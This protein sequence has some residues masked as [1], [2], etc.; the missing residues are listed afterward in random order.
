M[1]PPSSSKLELVGVRQWNKFTLYLY[2]L[3]SYSRSLRY[4]A[5]HIIVSVS[6]LQAVITETETKTIFLSASRGQ[7]KHKRG[8]KKKKK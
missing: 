3:S 1:I 4:E 8:S 6:L 7:D 2:S 5:N